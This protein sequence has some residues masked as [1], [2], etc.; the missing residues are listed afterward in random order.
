M[1]SEVEYLRQRNDS[2]SIT[3]T[4]SFPM[5]TEIEWRQRLEAEMD[6]RRRMETEIEWGRRMN[7][8]ME[9]RQCNDSF[10][11]MKTTTLPL[12]ETEME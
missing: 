12:V 2:F 7:T 11:I 1:E 4:S 9:W 8:E 10:P 3:R 6:W 5:D